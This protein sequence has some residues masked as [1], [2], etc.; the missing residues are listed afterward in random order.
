MKKNKISVGHISVR[1]YLTCEKIW[2]KFEMKKILWAWSLSLFQ[3]SWITLGC[4]VKNDWCK[5][6]KN[7]RY[8]QVLIYWKRIK[9]N[10]QHLHQTL[11]W[12]IYMV[13]QW[14]NIFLMVGFEWLKNVNKFGAMS[15]SEKSPIG[16]FLEVDL[17]YSYELHELHNIIH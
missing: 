1:D 2:D 5:I 10:Y 6:R 17:E 14:A 12:I 15:V 11:T 7:I 13:G 3:F 16:Y 4:Y 9:R 8:W